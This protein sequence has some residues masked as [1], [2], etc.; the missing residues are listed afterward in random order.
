MNELTIGKQYKAFRHR[1]G[2]SRIGE[3]ELI[4]TFDDAGRNEITIYVNN[5][6]SQV[7]EGKEFTLG[8]INSIRVGFKKDRNG[9]WKKAISI[10]A[11]VLP[12]DIIIKRAVFNCEE[13]TETMSDDDPFIDIQ[14]DEDSSF[15]EEEKY[16]AVGRISEEDSSI[17]RNHDLLE[18][19][20]GLKEIKAEADEIISMAKMQKIRKKHNLPEIPVSRHLVFSGNPGSGKTTVARALAEE[21]KACGVLSKGHL[22]EVSRSDLVAEYVGQ[23]AVK[24]KKILDKARGGVLFIDEAYSLINHSSEDYGQEAIDT[25]MKAMEDGRDDLVV[26]AAGYTKPMEKFLNSN[27]GLRSRFKHTIRF[28]DYTAEEMYEIFV[29]MLSKFEYRLDKDADIEIRG[30]L[31]LYTENKPES[32]ANGRDVRNLFEDI[33]RIQAL[34]LL[35]S[36]TTDND[37]L[38]LIRKEDVIPALQR[39][40]TAEADESMSGPARRIG[41]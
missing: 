16:Q 37:Q 31:A 36:G 9:N 40:K 26:I 15:S 35:K 20:I 22:V 3:W 19:M 23:T 8:M 25:I 38:K 18:G 4:T 13:G 21:Y 41:F 32:F 7:K 17:P 11:D 14:A 2:S 10:D 6:P 28:P 30:H 34:R 12:P 39:M 27:P 5:R 1:T 33:V 29:Q 24:T